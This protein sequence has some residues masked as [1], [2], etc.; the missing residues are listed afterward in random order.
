MTSLHDLTSVLVAAGAGALRRTD[1]RYFAPAEAAPMTQMHKEAT[2]VL[3][4]GEEHMKLRPADGV[5]QGHQPTTL[6]FA[7]SMSE[8]IEA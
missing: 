8:T 1:E 2:V 5:L 3:T 4:V 7:R 6:K